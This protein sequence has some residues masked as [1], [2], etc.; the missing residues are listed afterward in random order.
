MN[1]VVMIG[2]TCKE[3]EIRMTGND[4]K[5]TNFTLAVNKRF[6]R[7]GDAD[8]DFINCVAFGK[9]AGFMEQYIGKGRQIAVEGRLQV[10]NYMKD[11]NK[12]YVTEVVVEQ[13][14]FADSKQDSG[15]NTAINTDV[16]DGFKP[17]DDGEDELP[18]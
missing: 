9:T 12:I 18:F 17:V 8:A 16:N 14:Y 4:T 6:K 3:I 11:D 15:Q 10:R 5:V 7:E 13:V 1:K 2:R